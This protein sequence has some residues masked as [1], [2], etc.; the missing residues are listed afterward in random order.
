[1]ARVSTPPAAWSSAARE[2]GTSEPS[3]SATARSGVSS[4]AR[5]AVTTLLA[6]SDML[7]YAVAEGGGRDL[8][9][10]GHEAGEIVRDAARLDR[11]RESA[12]D[13]RGDVAPAELVEHHG[14]GQDYAAGVDLVLVRVL[15]G[16]AVRRLEH[17]VAV[18][19]EIGRA[20]CRE[21]V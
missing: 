17:G 21:R 5:A 7:D 9:G 8:G 6:G 10:V 16:G 3:A 15:R 1:M 12:H 14:P 11:A 2:G 4:A 18:A 20:S 13:R 19:D